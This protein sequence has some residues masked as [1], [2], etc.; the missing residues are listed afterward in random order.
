MSEPNRA[1]ELEEQLETARKKIESLPN[2]LRRN[3]HFSGS[4]REQKSEQHDEASADSEKP[5][6]QPVEA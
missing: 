4:N 6:S 1:T 3:N 5:D 2:W